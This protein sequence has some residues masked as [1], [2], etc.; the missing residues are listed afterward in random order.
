MTPAEFEAIPLILAPILDETNKHKLDA[1]LARDPTS[2]RDDSHQ[3]LLIERKRLA[4]V[5]ASSK[6]TP[7]TTKST[8]LGG[9]KLTT[10]KIRAAVVCVDCDK[11]CLLYPQNSLYTSTLAGLI[12]DLDQE[13][14]VG[15]GPV[16]LDDHALVKTVATLSGLTGNQAIN[17]AYYS[18]YKV[19]AKKHNLPAFV[20]L[21]FFS[22]ASID[23][24]VLRRNPEPLGT[25][26]F[27]LPTCTTC[28][29]AG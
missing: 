18:K 19:L 1:T 23:A 28:H 7:R 3:P 25:Y 9:F 2:K 17:S 29:D 20:D 10:G 26:M 4:A 16:L 6:A 5:K 12:D 14:F 11:P 8:T 15:G 27:I 22:C 21:R 13:M 24:D